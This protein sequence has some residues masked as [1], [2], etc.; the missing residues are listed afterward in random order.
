MM[1][2]CMVFMISCVSYKASDRGDW[3]RLPQV[4][5]PYL[6]LY[7]TGDAGKAQLGERNNN[8]I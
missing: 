7:L 5:D 6:T 4:E 3:E 2:G 1:F 8:T